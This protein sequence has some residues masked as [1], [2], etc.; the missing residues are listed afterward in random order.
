MQ[1]L[2]YMF[3]APNTASG[4][5]GGCWRSC[6]VREDLH[7]LQICG[8][9]REPLEKQ[10]WKSW[11]QQVAVDVLLYLCTRGM[12]RCRHAE[13]NDTVRWLNS[14]PLCAHTNGEVSSR[15]S[16]PLIPRSSR[17]HCSAWTLCFGA[18]RRQLCPHNLQLFW[19]HRLAE[20]CAVALTE[21]L[22][23]IWDIAAHSGLSA[24]SLT[25]FLRSDVHYH[26]Y[27]FVES[28]KVAAN[29]GDLRIVQWLFAHFPGCEVPAEVVEAVTRKGDLSIL[30][31]CL[32]QDSGRDRNNKNFGVTVHWGW[33]SLEIAICF[34]HM[35]VARWLLEKKLQDL[36]PEQR[37]TAIKLS[38]VRCS[39]ELAKM[40]LHRGKCISDYARLASRPEERWTV[41]HVDELADAAAQH[42]VDSTNVL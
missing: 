6:R 42:I 4:N 9:N 26:R 32:S 18:D 11:K 25:R 7:E 20:A 37:T 22:D 40:L 19:G 33:Y 15:R 38:L 30:K 13:G 8:S 5:Q 24:W 23:W 36:T 41:G 34:D 21:F 3:G 1:A 12:V 39:S 16:R 27:Q 10:S 14:Y 2:K 31:F 29:R 35:D 28:L 17:M